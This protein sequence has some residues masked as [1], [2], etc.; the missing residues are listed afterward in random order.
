[1]PLRYLPNLLNPLSYYQR[2]MVQTLDR[3]IWFK[4]DLSFLNEKLVPSTI[5]NDHVYFQ[6]CRSFIAIR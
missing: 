6:A 4:S 2:H 5:D 3:P 1:V